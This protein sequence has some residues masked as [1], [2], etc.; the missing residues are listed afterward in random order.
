MADAGYHHIPI[1]DEEERLAGIISQSD[2]MAALYESR[3]AEAAA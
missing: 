3:F 2:L 1:L